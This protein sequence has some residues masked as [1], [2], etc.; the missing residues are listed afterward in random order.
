MKFKLNQ[1]SGSE[2]VEETLDEKSPY[3]YLVECIYQLLYYGLQTI[4]KARKISVGWLVV[5]GLMAL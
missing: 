1:P 2:C 4:L 3:T 5:L